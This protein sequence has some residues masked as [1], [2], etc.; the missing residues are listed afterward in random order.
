ML[1]LFTE[2]NPFTSLSKKSIRVLNSS[3][4]QFSSLR[5]SH[6]TA[7][8]HWRHCCFVHGLSSQPAISTTMD[9]GTCSPLRFNEAV[10]GNST[11]LINVDHI[12]CY[13]AIISV[14]QSMKSWI[15]QIPRGTWLHS[16]MSFILWVL[17]LAR[18]CP[19]H[20]RRSSGLAQSQLHRVLF[21][22]WSCS[23]GFKPLFSQNLVD[24]CW[25]HAETSFKQSS[26]SNV[27]K[28]HAIQQEQLEANGSSLHWELDSSFSSL[29]PWLTPAADTQGGDSN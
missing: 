5:S 14:N 12:C 21:R 1:Y 19:D 4:S 24:E 23:I 13:L 18:L 3:A 28:T 6:V 26:A 8:E 29:K 10:Y 25:Q 22:R 27:H 2:S 20:S 15:Y 11:C 7:G 9:S 16:W 17:G